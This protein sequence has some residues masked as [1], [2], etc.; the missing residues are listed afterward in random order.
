MCVRSRSWGTSGAITFSNHVVTMGE[1]QR[2]N[3]S[4]LSASHTGCMRIESRTKGRVLNMLRTYKITTYNGRT[5]LFNVSGRI[6]KLSALNTLICQ[7]KA[8]REALFGTIENVH[9]VKVARQGKSTH[10]FNVSVSGSK[11]YGVYVELL[12]GTIGALY[13]QVG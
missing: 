8:A 13:P 10:H 2:A 9:S 11:P 5:Y 3:T 1:D 4:N 7:S 12:K 6:T